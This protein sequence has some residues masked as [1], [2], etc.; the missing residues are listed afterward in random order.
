MIATHGPYSVHIIQCDD[1]PRWYAWQKPQRRLTWYLLVCNLFGREQIAVNGQA[2]NVAPGASYLV[3]PGELVD[4][5][6]A[7]GNR[8]VWIHFEVQHDA[9]RGKHP[10]AVIYATDWERRKKF[11]QP[12]PTEVWGVD[13]PLFVPKSLE[14]LF[15]QGMQRVVSLWKRQDALS[16]MQAQHALNG[17]LLALVAECV[18]AQRSRGGDDWQ[19][20]FARAE[21]LAG[22][23]LGGDF[24]VSEFAAAAG[25]SR[26]RFS[27]LYRAVT[28]RTPG[29]FLRG[30]RVEQAKTLLANSQLSV[31][32]VGAMVGYADPTIFARVF[33]R[34]VG[35]TPTDYRGIA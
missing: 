11:A 7:R 20:R 13:L 32:E 14:R 30:L 23:S 19:A 9:Y 18:T 21:A 25:L 10:R 6:S 35:M 34:A 12:Q 1:A 15:V 4:L 26:T 29:A 16:I 33:R 5:A 31:R 22:E 28:G 17:L 27:V 8:P 2:H 24:G 3:K